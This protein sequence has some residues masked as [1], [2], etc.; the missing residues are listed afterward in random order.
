[1]LYNS[2]LHSD[3]FKVLSIAFRIVLQYI[4]V[5]LQIADLEV[6]N[7]HESSAISYA[8]AILSIDL[9]KVLLASR[10]KYHSGKLFTLRN[11]ED[12]LEIPW[13]LERGIC[14]YI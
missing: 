3:R 12:R 5:E 6:S 4:R 2:L 8:T 10:E 13:I 14:T 1:V 9:P 7:L 11:T